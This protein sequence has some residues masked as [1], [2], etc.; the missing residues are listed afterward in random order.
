MMVAPFT[1][2]T[3]EWDDFVRRQEA[4]SH[5]HLHGWRTVLEQTYGHEGVYLAAYDPAGS[6]A[7]VLPLVRVRSRLFG[8]FLVSMPFV[9]YGGP[10]G[11]DAA[12]RALVAEAQAIATRDAVKLLELRSRRALPIDLPASHR[13]ITVTLPLPAGSPEPLWKGF[14]ANVRRRVKRSRKAGVEIRFGIDQVGP[15]YEVFTRHMRDL[16]TP[17]HSRRLFD[18]VAEVFPDTWFGCA[19]YQGHPIAGIG[20]FVWGNEFEVTWASALYAHKELAANMHLY[21]AFMERCIERGISLF[22]F[23]RCTPGEGTHRFKLQWGS[24]DEALWWYQSGAAEGGGTPSPDDARYA[25]GPRLWK[26]LPLVVANAMGPRIVRGI[27]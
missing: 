11:S 14:D 12:V 5:F 23:G 15:F 22:N 10:L 24:N 3:A 26:K 9:N 25:W 17:V 7:G 8:H 6:L 19:W 16:G 21:W 2:S 1:G 27:P 20:G 18:T 13:K 4:W